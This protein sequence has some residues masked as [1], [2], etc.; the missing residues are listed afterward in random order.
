M[1]GPGIA[2]STLCLQWAVGARHMRAGCRSCGGRVCNSSLST[3]QGQPRMAI[4]QPCNRTRSGPRL[5]ALLRLRRAGST[6]SA[7]TSPRRC[8][9]GPRCRA[10]Q[11]RWN[12]ERQ[13]AVGQ[14]RS[15]ARVCHATS[16][17][18]M[19]ITRC[20][21]AMQP[22]GDTPA[23]WPE[24]ARPPLHS[25]GTRRALSVMRGPGTE[26][27]QYRRSRLCGRFQGGRGPTAGAG[28]I[29]VARPVQ[30]W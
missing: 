26:F 17:P 2:S 28:R 5:S 21:P 1:T 24:S 25:L 9:S 15:G 16:T 7:T 10:E 22:T 19:P 6:P 12:R 18:D 4:S 13:A 23:G 14:R 8:T 27:R 29:A 20:V 30:C 3:S 11:R